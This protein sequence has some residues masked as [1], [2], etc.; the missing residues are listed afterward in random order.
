MSRIKEALV[1]KTDE[2]RLEWF[3]SL[4]PDEQ[5][6]VAK[7]AKEIVDNVI[8]AFRPV[9]EALGKVFGLWFDLLYQNV[10]EINAAFAMAQAN[11]AC[12]GQVAGAGKADGESTP[13]ATCH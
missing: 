4:A 2:E 10:S 3:H 12:S 5:A 8:E 11:N 9:A 6:E 1:F 7:E 13:S